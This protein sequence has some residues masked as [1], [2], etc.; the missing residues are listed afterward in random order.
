MPFFSRDRSVD[1]PQ[2]PEVRG[3]SPVG[4]ATV[5]QVAELM[6]RFNQA[7]GNDQLLRQTIK[8]IAAAAG[9]RSQ[10]D[11]LRQGSSPVE[12]MQV[13]LRPWR[14]IEAVTGKAAADGNAVLA[15][16][17]FGF[18]FFWYN[19]LNPLLR[20]EDGLEFLMEPQAPARTLL[21]V[22]AL[23]LKPLG[24]L[25]AGLPV[26]SN[27]TGT[28]TAG[29]LTRAAALVIMGNEQG[30]PVPQEALL[31]AREAIDGRPAQSGDEEDEEQDDG[32]PGTMIAAVI[33]DMA[34]TAF[35]GAVADLKPVLPISCDSTDFYVFPDGSVALVEVGTE[36]VPDWRQALTQVTSG[37]AL[38]V[39]NTPQLMAWVNQ[40][41]R[42]AAVGK[43]Y[44]VT[45]ADGL[46]TVMYETLIWLG[47]LK[48]LLS[49]ENLSS[50][51]TALIVGRVSGELTHIV[52]TGARE[53]AEV[54]ERF[55]GR[56]FEP[57]PGD[58]MKLFAASMGN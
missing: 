31:A 8:G 17:I 6:D 48:V 23:A 9:L 47:S 10:A 39:P 29:D 54:V 21:D 46:A 32:F 2:S 38:D 44:C 57:A 14:M 13:L 43:Y 36:R 52:Q 41:N 27:Q 7:V 49:E 37:L 28:M 24:Q 42:T 1:R 11:I 15:G 12:Y 56:L 22:A 40:H 35:P 18:V 33:R 55:G 45:H 26:F 53:R 25:P 51:L 50:E 34:E 30:L 5:A 3:D 4:D 19:H 16:K 20:P 58:L